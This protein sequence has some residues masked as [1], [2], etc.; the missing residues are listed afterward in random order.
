MKYN[1]MNMCA[2]S[3]WL[4]MNLTDSNVLN[5]YMAGDDGAY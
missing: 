1:E 5:H 3:F 2:E 4:E